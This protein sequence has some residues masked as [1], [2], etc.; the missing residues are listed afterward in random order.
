MNQFAPRWFVGAWFILAAGTSLLLPDAFWLLLAATTGLVVLALALRHT[1][2]FCC[3]WLLI[4]G[5]TLEMA[6]GDAIGGNAYQTIIAIVKAAE[7]ALAGVCVLRYGGRTDPFNPAYAYVA[8]AAMG[9]ATGLHPDLTPHDS[10]RSLIGSAAPFLFCFSRLTRAWA[11][12]IVRTSS[13]IPVLTVIAGAALFAAGLRPLFVDSGGWRLAALGHPAFLGGFCLTAIYAGLVQWLRSGKPRELGLIGVNVAILVAT[14]ARAPMIYAAIVGLGTILFADSPAVPARSRR[15]LL[16]GLAAV[17]PIIFLAAAALPEIRLF[18]VLSQ[19]ATNLSGRDILWPEFE[20]AAAAAPWFGWGIGAGNVI[21]PPDS[22]VAQLIGTWAAHNEYLRMRVEGGYIG[23][24][25]LVLC[26]VL[27]IWRNTAAL[28]RGERT[29]MRLVFAAFACHA[30]TDN[31]L[32]ST[33]ACVFFAFAAAM[34]A[35]GRLKPE[36]RA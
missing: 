13:L 3:A 33:S 8:L 29:L 7:I 32:I 14:G 5:A 18:N 17:L 31:V 16:L 4:A 9:L 36:A 12:A 35:H 15:L 20:H 34:F 6:L 2:G 26:F 23:L 1:V 21:I 27:W 10:L 22:A 24:T 19:E 11:D 25:L 28:P 30:Y